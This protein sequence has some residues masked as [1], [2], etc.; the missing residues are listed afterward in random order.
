MKIFLT[1]LLSSLFLIT[2]AQK[3]KVPSSNDLLIDCMK[4][5]G[6]IPTKQMVIWFPIDFW[7]IVGK[8]MKISPDFMNKLIDNMSN[9]MTFAVVDYG[10]TGEADL[11][12]KSE[13][14]IRKS[15]KLIDSSKNI[16]LPLADNEISL[17]SFKII[18]AMK[19]AMANLLGQFGRGMQIFVFKA[20]KDKTGANVINITR[21][22]NFSLKWDKVFVSWQ[23]PFASV[24]ESKFCPIDMD[25]M[26]GNWKYCPT[27]GKK[28]D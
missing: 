12:F 23:M 17:E 15:I 24:L 8:Q 21:E 27:H 22:N 25:E 6:E 16:Y 13:E 7:I 9:Y 14:E 3:T 11:I 10:M 2:A 28:L 19:P 18:D 5:K 1:L 20:K 4:I 26:K